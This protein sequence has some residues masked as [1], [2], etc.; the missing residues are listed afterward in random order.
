MATTTLALATT[1]ER[2]KMHLSVVVAVEG[3]VTTGK[4]V[5]APK[6]SASSSLSG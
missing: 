5:V 3:V 1:K 4:I 2:S 6:S